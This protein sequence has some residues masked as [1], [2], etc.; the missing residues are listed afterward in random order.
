MVLV[1]GR[2]RPK[3]GCLLSLEKD[4]RGCGIGLPPCPYNLLG[5]VLLCRQEVSSFITDQPIGNA[6]FSNW[7]KPVRI[8]KRVVFMF[9]R[10][11][12]MR[13]LKEPLGSPKASMMIVNG[14]SRTRSAFSSFAFGQMRISMACSSS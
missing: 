12:G 7:H 6:G 14:G 5:V 10:W 9:G 4:G 3:G 8:L 1:G 2:K 13:E 11:F